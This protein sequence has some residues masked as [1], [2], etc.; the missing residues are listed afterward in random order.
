MRKRR[1]QCDGED[2]IKIERERNLKSIMSDVSQGRKRGHS[3][4]TR[5]RHADAGLICKLSRWHPV[6]FG[7]E[8]NIRGKQCRP[9]SRMLAKPNWL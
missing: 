7:L 9:D 3:Q 5:C 1:G 2:A 4:S 6:R 8:A